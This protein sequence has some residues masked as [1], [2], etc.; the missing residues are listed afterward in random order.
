[1]TSQL[2]VYWCPLPDCRAAESQGPWSLVT[3]NEG[4]KTETVD[5]LAADVISAHTTSIQKSE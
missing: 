3:E 4:S 5:G 1:M 2:A